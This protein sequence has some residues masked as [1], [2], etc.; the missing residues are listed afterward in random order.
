[1]ISPDN[2][3]YRKLRFAA[4]TGA[5]NESLVFDAETEQPIGFTTAVRFDFSADDWPTV[6]VT[7]VLGSEDLPLRPPPDRR[8]T[9]A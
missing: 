7:F 1:M 5:V 6:T 3:H 9:D 4:P 2:P 8:G